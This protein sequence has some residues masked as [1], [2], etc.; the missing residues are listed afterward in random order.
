MRNPE[1]VELHPIQQRHGVFAMTR[2]I[3]WLSSGTGSA[4]QLAFRPALVLLVLL[5]VL[6]SSMYGNAES[7]SCPWMNTA[8]DPGERAM[9]LLNNSTLDHQMRW[10]AQDPAN[11]PTQTTFVALFGRAPDAI[12]PVQVPCTP[13]GF[14]HRRSIGLGFWNDGSHGLSCADCAVRKLG[15]GDQLAKR[16][17]AGR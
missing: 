2:G 7:S 16:E 8:L 13:R 3:H 4:R 17:S 5:V 14:I 9:L 6:S 11:N 1:P 12:Y 10:L 15:S